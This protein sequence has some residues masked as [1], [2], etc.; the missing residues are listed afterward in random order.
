MT[1]PFWGWTA[2]CLPH[3]R[4]ILRAPALVMNGG[5]SYPFMRDTARA[6]ADS[7]PAGRYHELEG[8]RH[9]V[10]VEALAPVLVEFFQDERAAAGNQPKRSAA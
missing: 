1:N 6:L 3:G 7:I 8:Q 4:R 9:D 2:P 5:E 10:A